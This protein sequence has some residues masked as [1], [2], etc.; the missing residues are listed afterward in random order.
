MDMPPFKNQPSQSDSDVKDWF[1]TIDAG[2][3]LAVP[4][5]N[6]PNHKKRLIIGASAVA[7]I[8]LATTGALFAAGINPFST[9]PVC[10]TA[11]DYKVLTG[12][13]ADNQLSPQVFYT[14]S[15]DFQN[16]TADYAEDAEAGVKSLAQKIGSFYQTNSS[17]RSIV[18]TISSDAAENDTQEAAA[19][20][21]QSL[22]DLL[23]ANG[24]DQFAIQTIKPVAVDSSGELSDNSEELSTAKAYINVASVAGCKQ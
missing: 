7:F 19:K 15:F 9:A 3:P 14:E 22:K 20:R 6:T 1:N 8:F 4:P 13:E 11:D 16:G 12:S 17:K 5:S 21:I 23:V 24:V 2:T 18:V 10:L